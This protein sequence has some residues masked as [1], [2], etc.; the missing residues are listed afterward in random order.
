MS[1]D[2]RYIGKKPYKRDNVA[3]TG[4]EWQPGE[5]HTVDDIA[6]AKLLRH[7]DIWDLAGQTYEGDPG[8]EPA[9]GGEGDPG[10]GAGVEVKD[11]AAIRELSGNDLN[12]YAEQVIGKRPAA[13]KNMEGRADEV[14]AGMQDLG[15]LDENGSVVPPEESPQGG[16]GEK[17]GP[18]PAPMPPNPEFA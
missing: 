5:V 15:L 17:P 6:A 7:T 13:N 18:A 10:D 12:A 11:A 9:E 4:L 3:G 16:E 8:D 2:I 14:I 1:K